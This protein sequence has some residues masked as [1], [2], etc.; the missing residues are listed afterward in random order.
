MRTAPLFVL[1]AVSVTACAG[2]APDGDADSTETGYTVQPTG[3]SAELQIAAPAGVGGAAVKVLARRKDGAG[4]PLDMTDGAAKP[5]SPGTYCVWTRVTGT[6]PYDILFETQADCAVDVATGAKLVYHL[7][8]VTFFRSRDEL[9]F[10]LDVGADSSYADQAS[11]RLL[12]SAVAVPH[13][14]GAF[15]Y[16]YVSMRNSW[17]SPAETMLDSFAFTVAPNATT[18]VDLVDTASRFGARI[19]PATPRAL[20]N[21]QARIDAR[22]GTSNYTVTNSWF[23]MGSLGKP[24]LVRAKASAMVYVTAPS[25]QTLALTQP[26]SDHALGRLDVEDVAV[27]MPDG[28]TKTARGSVQ[29]GVLTFPTGS[30]IDL[31]PGTYDMT[32][33][34]AHPADGAKIVASYSANVQP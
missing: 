26:V 34:Y 32:V 23:D 12:A 28:S 9:L 10:G 33:S 5:V 15:E 22:V 29:V 27:T 8:A 4:M 18:K 17:G 21:T 24:L 1:L 13:A 25:A 19:V 3:S 16:T 7:G 14:N 6:N 30:G 20:P 31:L 2:A 11:R